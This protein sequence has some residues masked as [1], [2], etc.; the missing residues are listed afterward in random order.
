MKRLLARLRA[1]IADF[2]V[3]T[4]EESARYARIDR[5]LEARGL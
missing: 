1:L 2:R 5:E 3:A 4:D